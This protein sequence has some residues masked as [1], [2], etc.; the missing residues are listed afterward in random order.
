MIMWAS[1]ALLSGWLYPPKVSSSV[2]LRQIKCWNLKPS[3]GRPETSIEDAIGPYDVETKGE[4]R[5]RGET[6]L[7][8]AIGSLCPDGQEL[9]ILL[10]QDSTGLKRVRDQGEVLFPGL[11]VT[12]IKL[13]L[14][15]ML[16]QLPFPVC[17]EDP[18]KLVPEVYKRRL[19]SIPQDLIC[20]LL[21]IPLY[22]IMS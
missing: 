9:H 21:P 13:R 3:R 4:E 5:K 1:Q 12:G 7:S 22:R 11:W 16:S 15:R 2:S 19:F 17:S 10:W 8:L 18:Q 20:G 14:V 6:G